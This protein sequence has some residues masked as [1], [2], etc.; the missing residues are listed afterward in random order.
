LID[1]MPTMLALLG[2]EPPAPMDGLDL[3]R[4][5]INRDRA[6]YIETLSPLVGYGWASLHGLRTVDAKYIQAPTPEFYS[7]RADPH[8]LCNLLEAGN[9]SC[10]ATGLGT[11]ADGLAARLD[12]F[13]R[14]WP[15][16]EEALRGLE[17]LTRGAEQ[18]LAALGYV[19]GD[20]TAAAHFE[21]RPDPKDVLPIYEDLMSKS[22]LQLHARALEMVLEPEA[23]GCA[24]RQ[25]LLLAQAAAHRRPHDWPCLATLGAARFRLGQYEAA[26]A[27][28]LQAR[29]LL[30]QDRE[31]APPRVLAFLAMAH[32]RLGH[33]QQAR[34]ALEELRRLAAESPD[35]PST[36]TLLVQAEREFNS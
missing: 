20:V 26:L 31:S 8:E 25:A 7:L 36:R 30:E 33:I 9:P 16:P 14:R 10:P 24:R 17:P 19:R 15:P 28:L 12:E 32:R 22:P 3:T 21:H 23:D 1:V 13:M 18:K 29:R 11:G 6:M 5:A 27:A 2:I 34:S 35:D 4:A